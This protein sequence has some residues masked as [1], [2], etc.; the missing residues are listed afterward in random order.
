MTALTHSSTDEYAD[1]AAALPREIVTPFV[2]VVLPV[3]NEAEALPR[4]VDQPHDDLFSLGHDYELVF[5]DGSSTYGSG[6][7]LEESARVRTD[8]TAVPF[9]RNFGRQAALQAG[10]DEARSDIV[11]VMDSDLRDDA[12][13]LPRF[14]EAWRAGHDVVY[15]IRPREN[16]AYSVWRANS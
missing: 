8:M 4:L 14:L 6:E 10:L 5:V 3:M 12:R 7:W 13:A 9:S 11:V 15:A 16:R 1:P 2:S